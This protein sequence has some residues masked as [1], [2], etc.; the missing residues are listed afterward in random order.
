MLSGLFNGIASGATSDVLTA[1]GGSSGVAGLLVS[2]LLI[3]SVLA[4]QS[5]VRVVHDLSLDGDVFVSDLLLGDL[6]VL[7][8]LLGDVLRNVLTKILNGIVVSDGDFSGDSLDLSLF[9]VFGLFHFFGDSFDFSLVLV[10]DDFLF[11]G[12]VFDSA[13]S[14]DDFF[15]SVDGG[16]NDILSVLASAADCVLSSG[17]VVGLVGV[18]A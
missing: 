18:G 2:S 3:S 16:A 15:A 8:S 6:D 1:M 11:E 9:S 13:F 7:D 5:L 17:V 14:L 12:D 10:F 4:F